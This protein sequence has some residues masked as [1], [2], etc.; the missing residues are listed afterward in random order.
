MSI[1]D[2][3][4]WHEFVV[5]SDG[6]AFLNGEPFA[7]EAGLD[8]Y[9]SVMNWFT[10]EAQRTGTDVTVHSVE[11]DGSNDNWFTVNAEGM[12]VMAKPP[13]DPSS[14]ASRDTSRAAAGNASA[15]LPPSPVVPPTFG[16]PV[17]GPAGPS[18]P[19]ITSVPPVGPDAPVEAAGQ[20]L[21]RRADVRFVKPVRERPRSGLRSAVYSVTGGT[22]NLGLSAREQEEEDL[23]RRIKRQIRGS[24]NTA[25]LSFKG[26][27]GK[28]STTVGV[29][30]TLAEYRGD[31]PCAAD[32]NPDAGDLAER[33]LGEA[34]YQDAAPRTVSDIVRDAERID[35]LT[36]FSEYMHHANRLHVI[37][38]EQ[39]P[40]LSDALTAEDYFK[41]QRLV[42]KYY[43]VMLT[44][45]GTGVSH[46]A[47]SGILL[48]ADNLVI[49]SGYAVS[50]AK[51]A[52]ST[53]E[54][55]AAHGY[56][57]LARN[58][59]VVVTDK[60]MV[61]AR[62]DRRAIEETLAGAAKTL[63]V[64]PHDKGVADGDQIA[65]EHISRQTRLAYMK[66]AAAIVDGYN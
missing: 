51:R 30:M 23:I 62:V 60:E 29:G 18:E 46:P 41:V 52:R 66:I 45:C 14:V 1:Q 56:E 11:G 2:S 9:T 37:A 40:A 22:V 64:V 43:S 55:L 7:P 28:T 20:P 24:H 19:V 15:G 58:A 33:A 44:D 6:T 10:S 54:W 21:P 32:F 48:T 27:I 65:L 39:D 59:V 25:L 63:V 49:A 50:G 16:S 36:K 8:P 35:S 5:R 61:S 47:M 53:L 13:A 42:A 57:H 17:P 3:K 31:P 38:G 4:Q 12:M 26:G 34:L